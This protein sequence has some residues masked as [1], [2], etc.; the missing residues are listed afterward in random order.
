MPRLRVG[1]RELH[2]AERDLA[3]GDRLVSR[4]RAMQDLPEGTLGWAYV[5]FY[6]R[7][8]FTLPGDDP[9]MPA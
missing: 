9:S 7:H 3:L 2:R 6:R 4:L 8:G 1:E 5:D